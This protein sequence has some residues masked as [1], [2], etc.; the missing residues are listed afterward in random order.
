[1][2]K[3]ILFVYITAAFHIPVKAQQQNQLKAATGL[4]SVYSGISLQDFGLTKNKALFVSYGPEKDYNFYLRKSKNQRI[5]GWTT[6]G[7]GILLS[8]IGLLI[9]N[10]D[11]AT[12]HSGSSAAGVLTV[13]G[14]VSG[15]VS[16]PF[17]IM[18]GANKHKAKALL[19]TQ[20]TGPG[21][22]PGVSKSIVGITIQF[23][24]GS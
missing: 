12:N 3:I 17:M 21:V 2:K 11:Y 16:I 6:L 22:P 19:N 10:G 7:G 18:A 5:V 15:I 4:N 23:P 9:A 20:K 1:M 24:L 14:A 13:A 8:G